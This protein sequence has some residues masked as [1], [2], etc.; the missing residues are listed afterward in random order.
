LLQLQ[1]PAGVQ[2]APLLTRHEYQIRWKWVHETTA[3][4]PLQLHFGHYITGL[5][6]SYSAELNATLPEIPLIT[7]YSP[8]QWQ[9]GINIMLKKTQ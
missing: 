1:T 6:N 8:A 4:L 5:E 3:S 9:H 7:G 2:P